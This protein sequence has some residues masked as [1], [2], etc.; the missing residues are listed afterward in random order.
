MAKKITTIILCLFIVNCGNSNKKDN[1]TKT[2]ENNP[3]VFNTNTKDISILYNEHI[4]P[5]TIVSDK[6]N[7]PYTGNTNK[8]AFAAQNDT[9]RFDLTP[10]KSILVDFIINKKDTITATVVGASKP[11]SYNKKYIEENTGSYKVF[12]PEVHELV[13][14]A[15]ALTKRGREDS[16]MINLTS[17][18]YKSVINHFEKF[19]DHPLLD[20]LNKNVTGNF[21]SSYNYYYNIKMNACMYSFEK[22]KIVNNSP[23]NRLGFEDSNYLEELIPLLNDFAQKSSFEIF[24]KENEDYYESL[25][26][27]YYRLVPLKKMWKWIEE[28]FPNRYQSYKVYFSPLVGGA[29]STHEFSDNEFNETFMFINAPIL[30]DTYSTKEKEALLSRIVFTEIDHNYVNPMSSEFPETSSILNPIKC[31]N[32]D[33]SQWYGNSSSTFNEYMTWAIYT[34]YMYDNFDIETFKKAN[35]DYT[36]VMV[37]GRGFHKFKEFNDFVL[38]WYKNNPEK[39]IKKL[40][41]EV[42]RWIKKENCE[43]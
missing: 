42:I 43:D 26:S 4:I 5:F 33:E 1:P 23:F 39:P 6:L 37:N 13:N 11:V 35:I 20:S 34:L 9:I 2:I 25:I 7:F 28:K 40:Y 15:I 3:I 27:S 36:S 41:P 19:E 32:S 12:A 29:H 18:Y 14:I 17:N 22:N 38:I 30:S 16:N 24:Y 21:N 10:G 31:W 8:V